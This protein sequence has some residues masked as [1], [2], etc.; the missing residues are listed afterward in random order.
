MI[1]IQFPHLTESPRLHDA[2]VGGALLHTH[3][4][5]GAFHNVHVVN[6]AVTHLPHLRSAKLSE[7]VW[8][9]HLQES[10][11]WGGGGGGVREGFARD[12]GITNIS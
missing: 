3:S 5:G 7:K 6:V 1:P 10:T 4:A 8:W 11:S 12:R 9:C 2:N